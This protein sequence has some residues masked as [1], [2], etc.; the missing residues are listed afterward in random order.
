MPARRKPQ[1]SVPPTPRVIEILDFKCIENIP[2]YFVRL[3]IPRCRP[4]C[5]WE[6]LSSLA[7]AT[8]LIEQ[9]NA[10]HT[11]D[12]PPA[13][14][15]IVS[16]PPV[17]SSASAYSDLLFSRLFPEVRLATGA[18]GDLKV[19]GAIKYGGRRFLRCRDR[20]GEKWLDQNV[21]RQSHPLA[22]IDWFESL[23]LSHPSESQQED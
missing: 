9:F 7:S 15:P 22:L 14:P 6:P 5:S 2:H 4:W 12:P 16:T 18:S 13:P 19:I 3:V 21:V 10:T 20:D 17:S 23:I 1:P 8:S 11:V